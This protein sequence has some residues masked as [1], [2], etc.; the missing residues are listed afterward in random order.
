MAG[1]DWNEPKYVRSLPEPTIRADCSIEGYL[2]SKLDLGFSNTDHTERIAAK[3]INHAATSAWK[4]ASATLGTVTS[5][6]ILEMLRLEVP[7]DMKLSHIPQGT[8]IVNIPLGFTLSNVRPAC[9]IPAKVQQSSELSLV[10]LSYSLVLKP[11]FLNSLD[12]LPQPEKTSGEP[13]SKIKCFSSSLPPSPP[14]PASPPPPPPSPRPPHDV[15]LLPLLL[16]VLLLV[17]LVLLL[18]LSSSLGDT[19]N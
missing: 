13:N 15:L 3:L 17:L 5:P 12:W 16:L 14:P 6:I 9:I 11:M 10:N 19:S 8:A 1:H 18:L 7:A 4:L 2:N